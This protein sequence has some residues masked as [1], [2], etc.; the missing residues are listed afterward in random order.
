LNVGALREGG[1]GNAAQEECSDKKCYYIFH[2]A[3]R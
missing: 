3:T 2:V 1:C